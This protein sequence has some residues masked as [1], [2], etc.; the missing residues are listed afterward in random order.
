ME[1]KQQSNP[2]NAGGRESLVRKK[3]DEVS[4]ILFGENLS[5]GEI[6]QILQSISQNLNNTRI[7]II[8]KESSE[9]K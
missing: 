5:V 7:N 2:L 4:A 1:K 6:G 8:K 3:F 9:K